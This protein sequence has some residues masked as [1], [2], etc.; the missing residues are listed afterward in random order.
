MEVTLEQ[1][2]RGPAFIDYGLLPR[3]I[4]RARGIHRTALQEL[5]LFAACKQ[6]DDRSSLPRRESFLPNVLERADVA[7]EC[8]SAFSFRFGSASLTPATDGFEKYSIRSKAVNPKARDH[9]IFPAI[10]PTY[11]VWVRPARGHQIRGRYDYVSRRSRVAGAGGKE[12]ES[13]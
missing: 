6:T 5:A 7:L 12:E 4:G 13:R 10:L 11:R 8:R 3:M 9:E 2:R 1:R